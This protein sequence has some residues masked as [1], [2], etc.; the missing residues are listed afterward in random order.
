MSLTLSGKAKKPVKDPA[1]I[2]REQLLSLIP[3]ETRPEAYSRRLLV[4][5][6]DR[7]DLVLKFVPGVD[8]EGAIVSAFVDAIPNHDAIV[9]EIE[10][11]L[12]Q[13]DG[14]K[15]DFKKK[16]RLYLNLDGAWNSLCVRPE[17]FEEYLKLIPQV[18]NAEER[19]KQIKDSKAKAKLQALYNRFEA[20]KV[21]NA[22]LVPVRDSLDQAR[23]VRDKA[24]ELLVD[25]E[26]QLTILR[27]REKELARLIT[28]DHMI[29]D[30]RKISI[31]EVFPNVR[32]GMILHSINETVVE[33]MQYDY[34]MEEVLKAKPPHKCEFRRYDFRFNK[35]KNK[36][37]S[38]QEMREEGNCVEDAMLPRFEF[39]QW[40]SRGNTEMVRRLLLAGE[41]PN[42][43]G[44][45][46]V[47]AL[48]AAATNG[49]VDIVKMLKSVNALVDSRDKNMVT[50]L[51]A[52]IR[53]GH[54]D[55]VK[56][57]LSM[58][59]NHKH[60]DVNKRGSLFYALVSGSQEVVQSFLD[61]DN[62]NEVEEVWGFTPLH[63][64]SSRGQ[65][66]VVQF[67][68][69]FGCSIYVKDKQGRTPEVV[70]MDGMHKAVYELLRDERLTASAQ[71]V[72]SVP[73]MNLEI[74]IGDH[75]AL[76]PSFVSDAHISSVLCIKNPGQ[77]LLNIG[78]FSRD[79][80]S[81]PL[82]IVE[83]NANDEDT[84]DTSWVRFQ[85]H[86]VELVDFVTATI[87]K[88]DEILLI[89]DPSGNS[90][91]VAILAATLLLHQTRTVDTIKTC[92]AARPA[93]NVS[94]SL[95]RGLEFLQRNLDEKRM[96]RMKKKLRRSIMVSSAF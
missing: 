19:I 84:T 7:L 31:A 3:N 44:Y 96:K 11:K 56:L 82:K 71:L 93:V 5:N 21:E 92:A 22:K 88:G 77:K 86:F 8:N 72:H 10:E 64:A 70:A 24:R 66:E 16:N 26:N 18:E 46:G 48:Q 4:A 73:Q 55:I 9:K 78:W 79:N 14:L 74:W 58:G 68:I 90:T 33:T 28:D 61:G 38:L 50:P 29:A 59:A 36:W 23:E 42:A 89:C 54:I 85:E 83:V 51:L 6:F 49:H 69:N 65:I 94:M 37:Q 17:E 75:S 57:L 1:Q 67:L 91:S 60:T 27:E 47:S 12:T 32:V 52:A 15:H 95:H 34:V 30:E 81:P 35:F 62:C 76:D 43:C 13:I 53:K 80:T 63:I 20:I 41:D 45:S 87:K 2:R 40:A 25:N 39:V